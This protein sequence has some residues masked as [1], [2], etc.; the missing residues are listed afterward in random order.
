MFSFKFFHP[1]YNWTQ[2]D[3]IKLDNLM[4][5]ECREN[6]I[7][8]YFIHVS[9]TFYQIKNNLDFFYGSKFF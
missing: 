7:M 5:D 8:K 3:E 9:F 2:F 4:V 1:S 6:F